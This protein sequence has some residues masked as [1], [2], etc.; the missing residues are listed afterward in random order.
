MTTKPIVTLLPLLINIPNKST[1][2]KL[3]I[4]QYMFFS[5]KYILAHIPTA[6]IHTYKMR[7]SKYY[8]KVHIAVNYI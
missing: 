8:Q 6:Y 7:V 5:H 1:T 3:I 4:T 2:E